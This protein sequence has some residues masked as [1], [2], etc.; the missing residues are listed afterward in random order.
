MGLGA[1]EGQDAWSDSG[2]GPDGGTPLAES[3]VLVVVVE[4]EEVARTTV[5]AGAGV[6]G[7]PAVDAA[8]L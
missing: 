5:I 1:D 7:G 2:T 6:G 4:V 3:V 8:V